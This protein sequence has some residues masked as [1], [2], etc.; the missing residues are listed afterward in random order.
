MTAQGGATE[1]LI[2]ALL[3]GIDDRSST[4]KALRELWVENATKL[5]GCDPAA[6]RRVQT[7][8]KR[9]AN[10]EAIAE[11]L[12]DL[13]SYA[14]QRSYGPAEAYFEVSKEGETGRFL[15]GEFAKDL[16]ENERFL[17]IGDEGERGALW[18]AEDGYY[19]PHGEMYVRQEI[20]QVL[21]QQARQVNRTQR[22]EVV[23]QVRNACIRWQRDI[24]DDPDLIPLKNGVL[25]WRTR[26]LRPYDLT[27]DVFFFQIP[28]TY[29]PEARCPQIID[30]M[31]SITTPDVREAVLDMAALTLFRR[32]MKD[33]L[34]AIGPPDSAKTTFAVLLTDF[35]G[36]RNVSSIPLQSLVRD[37]FAPSG[38]KNKLLNV[39]DDLGTKK[40]SD[41]ATFNAQTGGGS[42][43]YE[44]KHCDATE[45]VPHAKHIFLA[46]KMPQIDAA[47]G[48]LGDDV[49]AFFRRLHAERFPYVF[50]DDP[51]P[52]TNQRKK[53]DKDLLRRCLTED[54]EMSGFLNI[55]VE[56]LPH[57]VRYG[58]RWSKSSQDSMVAYF[59]S[60]NS[61]QAFFSEYCA[62]PSTFE[63]SKDVTREAYVWYCDT[64]DLEPVAPR[65]VHECLTNSGVGERQDPV[66]IK[67]RQRWWT[68]ME[69]LIDKIAAEGSPE[70]AEKVRCGTREKGSSITASASKITGSTQAYLSS[71]T[72]ITRQRNIR[73][74]E[75]E[76]VDVV[77]AVKEMPVTPVIGCDLRQSFDDR[78]RSLQERACPG[79]EPHKVEVLR[80]SIAFLSTLE[81]PSAHPLRQHLARAFPDLRDDDIALVDGFFNDLKEL[82]G[83]LRQIKQSEGG[84]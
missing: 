32:P 62:L 39:Y 50:K 40:L 10:S 37:R 26:T 55:L 54:S 6:W 17:M 36:A 75:T 11:D 68:G 80:E 1:R 53:E 29:D 56:R 8:I 79:G 42:I 30:F 77:P 16:L 48:T 46:N 35:L 74:K 65:I 44:R 58:P 67:P 13:V 78:I 31:D 69:I 83:I 76:D 73:K 61:F 60:S 41:V 27:R 14:Q 9:H 3:L 52:G 71:I 81:Q 23:D 64:N 34:A 72:G 59:R 15:A 2:R 47:L 24:P 20:E 49:K 38:L 25:N 21:G 84:P 18:Y 5:E 4:D 82:G 43:R 33:C 66:N 70:V 28:V 7:I 45:F 22:I 12:E 57:V 63:V 51:E 19:H